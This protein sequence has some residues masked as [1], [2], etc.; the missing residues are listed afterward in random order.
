MEDNLL[1]KF[2]KQNKSIIFYGDDTWLK[3]FNPTEYFLRYEGTTS[4]IASDY[5]EVKTL[6]LKRLVFK[7]TLKG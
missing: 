6:N 1:K 4:F 3:L 5:D 7:T 2:K